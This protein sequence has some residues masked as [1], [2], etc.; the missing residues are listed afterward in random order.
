MKI[1]R[2]NK[3][4][5]L[6]FEEVSEAWVEHQAYL[7]NIQHNCDKDVV[8]E[9]AA[10]NGISLTDDEIEEAVYTCRKTI[11]SYGCDPDWVW[12]DGFVECI[13]GV[14]ANTEERAAS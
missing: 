14:L 11:D 8:I 2:N 13:S 6:T 1:T 12:G 9:L 4:Y 3:E 7:N 5:E 10:V